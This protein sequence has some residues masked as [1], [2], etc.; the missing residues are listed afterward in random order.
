[1]NFPAFFLLVLI[2]AALVSVIACAVAPLH[3]L[4][5]LRTS[6]PLWF[7]HLLLTSLSPQVRIP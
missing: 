5:S 2:T 7:L 4:R 3:P 6:Q 1:M